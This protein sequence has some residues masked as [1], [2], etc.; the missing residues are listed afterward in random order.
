MSLIKKTFFYIS[1]LSLS[2]I[3]ALIII[4]FFL[5]L[6]PVA[7][8][9]QIKDKIDQKNPIVSFKPHQEAQYSIGASFYQV[10]SNKSA[11]LSKK[12]KT[13]V[14]KIYCLGNSNIT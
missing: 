5:S 7:E 6:M 8:V 9:I 12:V 11:Q 10:V 1:W 14:G 4:E 3:F 2:L 13:K